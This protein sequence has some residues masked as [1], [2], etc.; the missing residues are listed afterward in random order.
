M[1]MAAF[2]NPK[3]LIGV[4]KKLLTFM[5]NLLWVRKSTKHLYTFYM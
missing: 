5:A 2:Y 4:E 1:L 3:C